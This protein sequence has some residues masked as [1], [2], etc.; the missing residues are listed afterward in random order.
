[1]QGPNPTASSATAGVAFASFLLGTPAT[2]S[3]TPAPALAMQSRYTAGF[4]QADWKLTPKLTLNIGLRYDYEQPRTDRFNQFANF[5]F[6]A[7]PP[8]QNTGLN[9]KGALSFVGVNGMSREQSNPDRN[10][11]SPRLG[12][13]WKAAKK[14]VIRGG[15]GMFYGTMIGV[16]GAG[17]N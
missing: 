10:N 2:G 9:L 11:F 4:L 7:T 12:F 13:A 3:V 17:A 5:D 14:T 6:N 8:L 15:A 1:T 16:G